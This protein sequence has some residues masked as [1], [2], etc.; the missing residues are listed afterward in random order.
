[1]K[2]GIIGLGFVGT[3]I[4]HTYVGQADMV[5]IDPH[6]GLPEKYEDL[7]D[8]DAVF[9]SVPSPQGEDG[10]CDTSILENVLDKLNE[11]GY[12]R[13]VIS[14]VTAPPK[15][16]ENLLAKYP[17]LVHAPEF[18]TAA[19]ANLDYFNGTFSI[20]G[21]NSPYIE[22]AYDVIKHG[23][24]KIESNV[25]CSI[26][27]AS[28]AK[29]TINCFLATKVMFMNEISFLSQV[30]GYEYGVIEKCILQDSRIGQSHTKVPGPDGQYGFGGACFPKDTSA[31]I[32]FAHSQGITLDILQCVVDLNK[33]L[34]GN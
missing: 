26:G 14:K 22:Q 4:H 8:T 19:N 34:R 32:S 16:Y 31:L 13:V 21:G 6:K 1:M 18:L 3:A 17:N 23:Q 7:L 24:K 10:S 11:V 9:V 12:N 29:Y 33:T 28:L 5:L 15:T 20:I 27:E 30:L 25:F 2:I